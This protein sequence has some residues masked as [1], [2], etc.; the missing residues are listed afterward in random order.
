M[1]LGSW[2]WVRLVHVATLGC[3]AFSLGCDNSPVPDARN[4]DLRVGEEVFRMFC[5]R[6]AR[7]SHPSDPNGIRFVGLCEGTTTQVPADLAGTKLDAL[8]ARRPQT[9]AALDQVLGD[10][11]VTKSASF[12]EDELQAFLSKLLPF[13]SGEKILPRSTQALAK[14]LTRLTDENDANSVEVLD[15]I[16]RLSQRTGY[17]APDRVLAALRPTLTYDR[18]DELTEALLDFVAE[19]GKGHDTFMGVL[20]AAAL[21]LAEPAEEDDDEPSTLR[22]ALELLL[23]PDERFVQAESKALEPLPVLARDAE[24]N[25]I[26]LGGDATPF[27]VAGR[28]DDSARDPV[29]TLALTSGAPAYETF[30]ANQTALA[31]LMRDSIS[32]IRR[33]DDPRSTIEK[34]LRMTRPLLGPDAQL[35]QTFGSKTLRYTGPDA[36]HGPMADFVHSL[37]MLL[38]LP[39]TR[40]LLEVVD[41]LLAQDESAAT[42]LIYAV[43]KIDAQSDVAG[44]DG[45]KLTE[46][47]EFWDDLIQFG[48]RMIEERPGLLLDVLNATLDPRTVATGPVLAH[49]MQHKDLV[50]LAS[51]DINSE[52]TTGCAPTNG[53]AS[54][55]AY[56][57][58]VDRAL[59][60]RGMNRSLFQRTLSLI[61]ATYKAPNCNKEGATLTVKKPV[62]TTFP[63]PP[64]GPL[65]P[66]LGLFGGG[67]GDCPSSPIAPPPATSYARCALIEQKNSTVT[68]MRAM[69]KQSKV[70]IKDPSVIS[71][72][73]AVGTDAA[74]AQEEES[75]IVGFNL[76][77]EVKPL[78]RFTYG[79][80][81]K[82]LTDLF[83]PLA[84]VHGPSVNDF[85]PNAMYPL[86]VLDPAALIDGQ[87]QSFLT[88]SLPLLQAFDAHDTIDPNGDPVGSYFFAELLDLL[89]MHYSSQK[90][91][92][93]PDAVVKDNEGCTQTV[94]PTAK[95]YSYGSNLVSYEPLLTWALLDQDLL[96]VLSRSTAALKRVTVDGRD[97]VQILDAFLQA[98]L[99]PQDG[100]RYRD[101]RAY[102]ATNACAY[103][104][105]NGV[106]GCRDGKGRII[107]GGVP[108]LYLLLDALRGIDAMWEQHPEQ[109]AL[110]LEVRSTLV[111]KLLDVDKA[112]DGTTALKNR[113]AYALTRRALPFLLERIRA[114]EGDLDDWANGLVDRLADVLEHPLATRGMDLFDAFW[115]NEA[116]GDEV[117][118][119]LTYLL[120]EDTNPEAFT[121]AIVALADTLTFLDKD[122]NLTPAIRFAALGLAENAIDVVEGT[123]AAPDI[124]EGTVYRFLEATRAIANADQ[125]ASQLSAIAKLLRNAVLPLESDQLP[126][127]SGKSPLEVFI[128]VVAEVNRTDPTEPSDTPLSASDD[129]LVF[130]QLHDFLS[131]DQIGLE[132]LY[133]VIENRQIQQ[134]DQ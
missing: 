25:A 115:E 51:D 114:H 66:V 46:G 103:Q 9:V 38:K 36:K 109:H 55:P 118:R 58:P 5:M 57:L 126:E 105:D 119:L 37:T 10:A 76:A 99:M 120:D 23:T 49:Q 45:G 86:E 95:F 14:V 102:A 73:K 125:D 24:G 2:R 52:V 108:P 72:A 11:P 20:E 88:A 44:F 43:L 29:T 39:E 7:E 59:P 13:Y 3:L 77:P 97:G 79:T 90:P 61:H 27:L 54:A 93:C 48:R 71:C 22:L 16:A 91:E 64:L 80:R 112:A 4:A 56:C 12:E 122:P 47:N 68:L 129:R 1:L 107:E 26:S 81:N 113:R 32:L 34:L 30:D 117:A 60:D 121:G 128:D 63:N 87:P 134:D 82:F 8:L 78:S 62:E 100:M 94:D 104:E 106:P 28:K 131:S 21:E 110:Y 75:G 40:P 133:R 33:G 6:L 116:A 74:K 31:S 50:R 127:L 98:V 35:E 83:E 85:E 67:S 19:G 53:A 65:A 130:E 111:D 89:H 92:P 41:Q 17:R 84:T 18:L 132:R 101:G 15:T 123:A 124:A 69:L 96:G 70:V 42:E